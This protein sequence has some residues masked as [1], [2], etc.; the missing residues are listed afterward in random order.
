[1]RNKNIVKGFRK[2][3]TYRRDYR[4]LHRKSS[5]TV[6]TFD[7]TRCGLHTDYIKR[8]SSYFCTLYRL[9]NKNTK[10]PCLVG[11]HFVLCINS[12]RIAKVRGHTSFARRRTLEIEMVCRHR[13]QN[14]LST[15]YKVK[16]METD[17]SNNGCS[18]NALT[19]P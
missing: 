10:S 17:K 5:C 15:P 19:L 4:P 7:N 14:D 3:R 6:Y 18:F 9:E 16:I 1:M 11:L 2:A 8:P 12:S 13:L